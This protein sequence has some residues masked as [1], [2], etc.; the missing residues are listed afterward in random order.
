[1]G[2]YN[3]WNKV[4]KLDNNFGKIIQIKKSLNGVQNISIGHR[5]QQGLYF[6]DE[7]TIISSE[8]GPK[9]GDEINLLNL[10]KLSIQNFGWPISSYGYHYDSVPLS[11]AIT[12]IAPLNKN[13]EKYGFIEPN[14]YFKDIIGISEIIKNFYSDT[15]NYFVT[16]LKNKTIYEIEF[17]ENFK[18]PK[19]VDE[20]LVGER[21]RD[22]VF[23]EKVNKYYLYLE[24][25]PKLAIMEKAG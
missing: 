20:I 15:N 16:S 11:K 9:G 14:Y 21:I 13:H 19:I 8:H 4:Q 2:D 25:T 18:N 5:N 6:V 3:Q 23:D 1:M 24:N 7:N 10:N 17:D 22:I 12:N